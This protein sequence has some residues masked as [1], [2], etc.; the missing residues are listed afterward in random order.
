MEPLPSP[1][2][3]CPHPSLVTT[4]QH[5]LALRRAILTPQTLQLTFPRLLDPPVLSRLTNR[6]F[7][8]FHTHPGSTWPIAIFTSSE[9]RSLNDTVSERTV[10]EVSLSRAWEDG[11]EES[12]RGVVGGVLLE[13]VSG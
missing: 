2:H 9:Y 4:P 10:L 7:S 1:N 3:V 8:M 13:L 11:D 5:P 6:L 12:V